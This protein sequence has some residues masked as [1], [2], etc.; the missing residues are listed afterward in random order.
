MQTTTQKK[1]TSFAKKQI[2]YGPKT[3]CFYSIIKYACFIQGNVA[4][5]RHAQHS[6]RSGNPHTAKLYGVNRI[7]C[8]RHAATAMRQPYNG[9]GCRAIVPRQPHRK[10]QPE[11][12]LLCITCIALQM[13]IL[14][15]SEFGN[16]EERGR[17]GAI[18]SI[19][20]AS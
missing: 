19:A 6:L 17:T 20:T 4:C 15:A 3:L 12:C 11:G 2:Y 9:W 7:P 1:V 16:S 18:H 13:L 5:L 10:R 14:T 8:L